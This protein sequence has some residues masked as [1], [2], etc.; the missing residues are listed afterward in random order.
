MDNDLVLSLRTEG[1]NRISAFRLLDAFHCLDRLNIIICE[2]KRAD[3]LDIHQILL[4]K[5]CIPG[6]PHIRL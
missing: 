2:P 6:I 5:V 1:L 4:I 3:D